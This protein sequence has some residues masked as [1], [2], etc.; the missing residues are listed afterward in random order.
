MEGAQNPYTAHVKSPLNSRS[1]SSVN[2]KYPL[3]CEVPEIW[4]LFSIEVSI[5]Y[6]LFA[7]LL[8][9]IDY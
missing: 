1:H 3:L 7:N 9:S 8:S 2:E 6:F 4:G 5:S